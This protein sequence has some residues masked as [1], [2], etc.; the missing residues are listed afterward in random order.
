MIQDRL[1]EIYQ[2]WQFVVGEAWVEDTTEDGYVIVKDA[3][4][5]EEICAIGDLEDTTGQD[6]RRTDFIAHAPGDIR[7]LLNL[8]KMY[9]EKE[10]KA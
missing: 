4:T 1:Y 9:R 7:Y 8:V 2:R 10:G 5:G 6:H 3:N